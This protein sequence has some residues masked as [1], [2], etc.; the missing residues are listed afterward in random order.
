MYKRLKQIDQ[1]VNVP[2]FTYNYFK[3]HIYVKKTTLIH[4]CV[5]LNKPNNKL[6][7]FRLTIQ[8][9]FIH[10]LYQNG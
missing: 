1:K 2:Y 6:T 3:F 8:K 9:M 7:H 4:G 10:V 5:Y